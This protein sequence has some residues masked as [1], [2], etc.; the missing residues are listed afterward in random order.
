MD[1]PDIKP[2]FADGQRL[3]VAKT[4]PWQDLKSR[5]NKRLFEFD[6]RGFPTFHMRLSRD[7][8]PVLLLRVPKTGEPHII[9]KQLVLPEHAFQ[10]IEWQ[11]IVQPRVPVGPTDGV[12][13][14]IWL[15]VLPPE[16]GRVIISHIVLATAVPLWFEKA[17]RKDQVTFFGPD[18]EVCPLV[19][20]A[21]EVVR[22]IK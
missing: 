12:T 4:A 14:Q 13:S 19:F 17:A 15:G 5:L 22:P 21:L 6:E 3:R 18:T 7:D 11:G 2:I 16:P 20:G 9:S 8:G 1:V 10:I